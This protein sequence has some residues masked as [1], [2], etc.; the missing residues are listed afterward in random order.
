MVGKDRPEH[1]NQIAERTIA[2]LSPGGDPLVARPKRLDCLS[3][4]RLRQGEPAGGG[5][6]RA[7]QAECGRRK[8]GQR[9]APD[10]LGAIGSARVKARVVGGAPGERG[11]EPAPR[12]RFDEMAGYTNC[13]G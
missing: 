13:A 7:G 5:S 11:S 12:C 10:R 4:A 8:P 3:A 1:M 2:I 6:L 9:L